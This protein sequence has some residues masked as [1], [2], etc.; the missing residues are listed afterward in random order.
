MSGRELMP[1]RPPA[2]GVSRNPL[3]PVQ[4]M[5]PVGIG[6]PLRDLAPQGP[7][8]IVCRYNGEWLL[9]EH[10]AERTR[11]GDVV[12]WYELPQDKDALRGV[13]QIA[14]VAFTLWNPLGWGKLALF[15]FNIGSTLA[16]NALLPIQPPSFADA[17]QASPTYSASLSGNAAR[18]YQPIP[19]ICGRHKVTP[20]F[21]GQPYTEFAQNADDETRQDQFYYA[22]FAVGVGNHTIERALIDD[23][24]I[25]HFADVL[26]S[27][28]LAPGVQPSTVLANVV[29][30]PEVAGQDL[31]TGLYVGG[32]A[33]CGALSKAVKIGIDIVAPRGLGNFSGGWETRSISV[34]IE[35]REINE[36]GSALAPWSILATETKTAA[37]NTPQRWSFTYALTTPARVEVRVVR[38]DLRVESTAQMHDI[39]WSG[40]RAYL[41]EAAPLN[42]D[43]AHYEVVMRASE[44][45]SG[46]SQRNITLIVQAHAR[47]WHPSTGWGSTAH[48]RNPAW[49]LADLWT[50][51]AWGEELPDSRVD[52]QTL[53][54]MSLTA[55][56]RQDRFDYVFDTGMD[57]WEAAQLIARSMRCRVFRR[58]GVMTLARDEWVDLPV[59][60][61]TPRNCLP[62]SMSMS[63]VLPTRDTAD[64]IIVEYFDNRA[65]E[66]LS[67]DC[68]CPGVVSMVNPVIKRMPGITGPTHAEREGLYEAAQMLY[69]R[70]TVACSTEMQG[71][72]PHY[73]AA[74]RWMPEIAGYGQSGDVAFWDPDTLTMGLSEPPAWTGADYLT[75]IR[76]DGS[77]TTPVAVTPGAEVHEVV[78]PAAPDF[79]LVLDD[80]MRERPKFLFGP[81]TG[82]ELVKIS[83]ISDGGKG[84]DGEQLFDLAAVVDDERVHLVDNHLLPGPGDIQDPVGGDY[85][86]DA[87]GGTLAIVVLEDWQIYDT[88]PAQPA[89]GLTPPTVTF[90]TDGTITVTAGDIVL[91]HIAWSLPALNWVMVTPIET[92]QAA[93][94][95]IR[96][97][98][99]AFLLVDD[100]LSAPVGSWISLGTERT[101]TGVMRTEWASHSGI[102][103]KAEIRDAASGL[104]QD[105]CYIQLSV[106]YFDGGSG[107]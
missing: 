36:F 79:A 90:H 30:S 19:K 47:T 46:M 96:V 71:M 97:S 77:L 78:L 50:S 51:S 41:Q 2:M 10:W 73:M 23:T 66:W 28:Y 5:Q 38:T 55:E 65:W 95:E 92:S 59:T 81:L 48:T 69:R 17:G 75:L 37:T 34:R 94:F 102:A 88:T 6:V 76:D 105:Q 43:T 31:R 4:Q 98:E 87:G 63:E 89:E 62:G 106:Q 11:P 29:T 57:A 7:G 16:I 103:F 83:A 61:F 35:T 14:V 40:L 64:G 20:P 12:E 15:A 74:V 58:N 18:L 21:A 93:Q 33:A 3:L 42:A 67:I 22:L 44:Q 91:P 100:T 39:Q 9:R 86:E 27:Q 68:P 25:S 54:E 99:T 8:L 1:L 53:Y 70:R 104:L 82:D 26:V 24:P 85:E 45:L 52:L 107:L 80:G 72:L 49:W 13:L 101:W 60:A 32:F 56:A 84:E